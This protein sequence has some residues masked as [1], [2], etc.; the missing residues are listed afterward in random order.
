MNLV[1]RDYDGQ[2]ARHETSL[3]GRVKQRR[4]AGNYLCLLHRGPAGRTAF[5]C[6]QPAE[7]DAVQRLRCGREPP[8]SSTQ[9]LEDAVID[10]GIKGLWPLF[11]D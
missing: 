10:H 4:L 9:P 6:P 5:S 8:S 1:E 2:L 11:V 3:R 7:V